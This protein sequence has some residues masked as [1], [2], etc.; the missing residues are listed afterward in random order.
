MLPTSTAPTTPQLAQLE[1][2]NYAFPLN[3]RGLPAGEVHGLPRQLAR[4]KGVHETSTQIFCHEQIC[5]SFATLSARAL[6]WSIRPVI[7]REQG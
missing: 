1:L 3:C 6:C 2:G 5:D 4:W 7:S